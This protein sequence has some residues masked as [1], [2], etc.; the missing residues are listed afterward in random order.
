MTAFKRRANIFRG[1]V[2]LKGDIVPHAGADPA[3]SYM[4]L[5]LAGSVWDE[6]IDLFGNSCERRRRP[7]PLPLL[8]PF[9]KCYDVERPLMDFSA[10]LLT[11][12]YEIPLIVG[13]GLQLSQ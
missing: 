6:C 8:N 3:E 1:I 5:S 11:L 13:I 4:Y 2:R 9:H 7:E 12:K 10:V